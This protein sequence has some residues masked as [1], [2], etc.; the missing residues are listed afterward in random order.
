VVYISSLSVLHVAA[1]R[2][3]QQVTEDGPLEPF[4]EKRGLYTQ[5]KLHA[6]NIVR[7]AVDHRNLAAVI[8]RP[9]QVF[10]P[11]GPLITPAVGRLRNNRLIIVGNGRGLLPLVY[12][13]DLIDAIMRA[14]GA[15]TFDGQIY[16][17][18]DDT[19]MTQNDLARAAGMKVLHLPGWLMY[20]TAACAQLLSK[21]LRRP[22]PLSIYRLRSSRWR[23]IVDCTKAGEQLGWKP[24]IGVRRG[25]QHTLAG[26][27]AHLCE[28]DYIDAALGKDSAAVGVQSSRCMHAR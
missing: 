27:A 11:G 14:A 24:R 16:H 1:I 7:E 10:G 21:V 2:K 28:E 4:P 9:G 23:A 8:L 19:V 3:G 15:D 12:V 20:S 22:A 13:D 18:V 26:L 17:V 6:E 25:L 5:T